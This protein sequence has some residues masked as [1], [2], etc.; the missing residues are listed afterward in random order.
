MIEELLDYIEPKLD[1]FQPA[2]HGWD[3]KF[4]LT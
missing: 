3:K 1:E 2:N 4:I